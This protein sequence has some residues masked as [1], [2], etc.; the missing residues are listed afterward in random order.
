MG[1]KMMTETELAELE[2]LLAAFT[3]CREE[4]NLDGLSLQKEAVALHRYEKAEAQLESRLVCYAPALIAAARDA[5]RMRERVTVLRE[6]E[7]EPVPPA[8]T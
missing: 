1:T 4:Y 6:A 8:S 2:R 3:E 5:E 7:T